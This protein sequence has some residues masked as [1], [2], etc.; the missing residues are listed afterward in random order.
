MWSEN[1]AKNLSQSDEYKLHNFT[2]LLTNVLSV[3]FIHF[4]R[5]SDFILDSVNYGKSYYH[6]LSNPLV[7]ILIC[8]SKWMNFA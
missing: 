7:N 8:L 6:V 4:K 2:C 5:I 3:L 1:V